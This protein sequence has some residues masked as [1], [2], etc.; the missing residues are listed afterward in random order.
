MNEQNSTSEEN[1]QQPT[2]TANA[3]E[4]TKEF[5]KEFEQKL[6][7]QRLKNIEKV[8]ALH[9]QAIL[10]SKQ[11]EILL[12][13]KEEELTEADKYRVAW[14]TLRLKHH[15]YTGTGYS[16]EKKKKVKAKEKWQK[17]RVKQIDN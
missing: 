15:T 11:Q 4:I 6:E 7:E 2:A 5:T 1:Q 16:E 10:T 13:I 14:T 3:E 8:R 9:P 17:N 12:S